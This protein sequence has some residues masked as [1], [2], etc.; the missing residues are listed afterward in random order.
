MEEDTIGEARGTYDG[1][2]NYNLG[3]GGKKLKEREHL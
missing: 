3:S 2:E 1:G